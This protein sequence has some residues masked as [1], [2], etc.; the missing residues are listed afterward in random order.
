[1]N[2]ASDAGRAGEVNQ[3]VYSAAKAGV[4]GFTKALAKESGRHGIRA[5]V[6]SPG[7]TRTPATADVI[8]TWSDE[9]IRRLYPLGRVGEPDDIAAAVLFFASD[10][11]SWV[12]GQVLSV[13]GGYFTAG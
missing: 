10:L 6:V 1:V 12:T 4:I 2:I 9:T 7:V 5:N 8:A 13:S 11:S 3:V